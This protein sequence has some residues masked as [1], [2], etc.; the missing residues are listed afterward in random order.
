M[1]RTNTTNISTFELPF[2][3]AATFTF[4]PLSP[5]SP[6]TIRI[7][8]PPSSS[9]RMPLHWHP[10]DNH[11]ATNACDRVSCLLGSL[12][13]YVAQGLS[14][15]GWKIAST[16]MSVKFAPGQRVVWNQPRKDAQPL[17]VNLVADHA[18][19]RNIC[20]AI[21]DRDIFPQL[22]STP[23]W[24]KAIFVILAL[25]PS[26]KNRLLDMILWMQLQTIFFNSRFSYLSRLRTGD[27]AVDYSAFWWSTAS[28]GTS[29]TA[30][31]SLHCSKGSNEN[32]ILG[33]NIILGIKG[34]YTE[35]TPSKGHKGE[36]P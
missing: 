6:N 31:K 13:V 14:D 26:W 11:S 15:G 27:K 29:R 5:T 2:P 12:Q 16:G 10:S 3:D 34:D 17:T 33:R 19:W 1:H 7:T 28:L 22:S 4:T 21:L 24:L 8:V 18:L 32:C 9:W 23:L 25:L 20:S 30:T 36:R 35:Y